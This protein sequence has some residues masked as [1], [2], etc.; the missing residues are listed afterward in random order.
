MMGGMG[1]PGMGQP[2]GRPDLTGNAP[3]E[4]AQTGHEA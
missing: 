3:A 2:M 1:S 4:H